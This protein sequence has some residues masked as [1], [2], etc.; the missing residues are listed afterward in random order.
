VIFDEKTI[1]DKATF[2][3]PHQYPVGITSVFVNGTAA[4]LNGQ[5]TNARSGMALRLNKD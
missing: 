3:N 1:A 5:L 4:I 2:E